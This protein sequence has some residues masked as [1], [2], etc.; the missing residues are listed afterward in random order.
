MRKILLLF[1]TLLISLLGATAQTEVIKFSVKPSSTSIKFAY[2]L[3]KKGDMAKVDYGQG[4]VTFLKQ[5]S[6]GLVAHAYD[7]KTVSSEDRIIT[8]EADKLDLI[9][10]TST[11]INGVTEIVSNSLKRFNSDV[12]SL[13]LT[14]K[15]DFS[16]C[17]SILEIT[18][19]NSDVQEVDLPTNPKLETFQCSPALFSTKALTRLDLSKCTR[20]TN[21]GLLQTGLDTIDLSGSPQMETLVISGLSTKVYPKA[22]LGAKAMKNLKRVDIKMCALTYDQLPDLNE[23]QLENFVVSKLLSPRIPKDKISGLTIDLS[24]INRQKGLSTTE[25]KTI[26]SWKSKDAQGKYSIDIPADKMIEKDGVFTFSPSLLD[27]DGKL[28][29]RCYLFNP[30]YPNIAYYSTGYATLAETLSMPAPLATLTV[31]NA[32]PG[33]NEE[34]DPIEE[35]P[36]EFHLGAETP[37]TVIY[38]NWGDGAIEEYTIGST[39]PVS[40]T[41]EVDLGAKIKLY[42]AISHLDASKTQLTAFEMGSAT[43]LKVLRLSQNKIANIDLS[44]AENLKELMI[45]D[46]KL[47]SLDLSGVSLLEELYCGWNELNSLDLTHTPKLSVLNCYN[48]KLNSINVTSLADLEIFVPSDN[49]FT[50]PLDLSKN[51]KLRSIDISNCGLETLQFGSTQMEKIIVFGNKLTKLLPSPNGIAERLYYIDIRKN[52]FDACAIN[53]LLEFLPT[54]ETVSAN[55]QNAYNIALAQNPGSAT[56]DPSHLPQSNETGKTTWKADVKGDASGCTLPEEFISITTAKEI[57]SYIG[58]NIKSTGEIIVKGATYDSPGYYQITDKAIKV[59]GSITHIDCSGNELTSINVTQAKSLKELLCDDNKLQEI[60]FGKNNESIV[61][62]FCGNNQLK[63]LNLSFLKNLGELSCFLNQLTT[64]DVSANTLL[65][66][67]ICREN[68]IIGVLDLSKQPLLEYLTCYSNSI[69]AI[70]LAPKNTLRHIEC[71]RNAI[72]DKEMTEFM[73]ALPDFAVYSDDEWDSYMGLNLQGLYIVDLTKEKEH[74]VAYKSDVDIAV[75]KGWP[76]YSMSVDK[77]GEEAPQPYEGRPNS[78]ETIEN[79]FISIY[80]NPAGEYVYIK[81]LVQ[82]GFLRL[83]S[84]S[85]IAVAEAQADA[86]GLVRFETKHLPAGTYF[87]VIN[88]QVHKIAVR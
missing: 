78:T 52:Q 63:Q 9:R 40:V 11:N 54:V 23:T 62:L 6:D 28:T 60:S 17:P 42:G 87:V 18:L 72:K 57:G 53:D 12:A 34:D 7:F 61:R 38:I 47:T 14:P 8:I 48:N 32:S 69:S 49:P 68:Q 43:S 51:N 67:L 65:T 73:N 19:N 25:E 2:R 80:P 31:T 75:A 5:E 3:A 37:N 81:G 77:Y 1:L 76:V 79:A 44:P 84:L 15:M 64:L 46:N 4:E 58:L 71:Q 86:L 41:K 82:G 13:V 50:T 33:K 45:T 27:K 66:S 55:T 24:H 35:I 26:F 21:V 83:F 85:G 36:V 39:E 29:V 88:N 74:N 30:G 56:Y 59:Y 20:L 10:L 70:R 16:K 22:L